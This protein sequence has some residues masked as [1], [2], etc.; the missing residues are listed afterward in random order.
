MKRLKTY[1]LFEKIDQRNIEKVCEKL[2]EVEKSYNELMFICKYKQDYF[3]INDFI[4]N[5]EYPFDCK[6]EDLKISNWVDVS[7]SKFKDLLDKQTY[8]YLMLPL[9]MN[10]DTGL[11]LS[12]HDFIKQFLK[13][14]ENF[15]YTNKR[16]SWEWNNIDDFDLND[17]LSDD[18]PYDIS[19]DEINFEGWN[20]ITN[21]L[22]KILL[23]DNIFNEKSDNIE[24][25]YN[26]H[27]LYK[28]YL[29]NINPL[30]K[31]EFQHKLFLEYKKEQ[32]FIKWFFN[33]VK[34]NEK[35]LE[36]YPLDDLD[37]YFNMDDIGLF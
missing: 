16:L 9:D 7:I 3:D 12:R 4:Y 27:K 8:E 15:C 25:F 32:D 31:F 37:T 5:S 24:L 34:P 28:K 30:E 21:E 14:L 11:S 36:M 20:Q 6:L 23:F 19:Y 17:Y 33:F 2:R 26:N 35:L 18:F 10:I 22:V 29:K 1:K 13:I